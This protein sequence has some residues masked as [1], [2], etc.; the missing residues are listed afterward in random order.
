MLNYLV[1][2]LLM[3]LGTLVVVSVIAFAI[4]QLPPGDYVTAYVGILEDGGDV[5]TDDREAALRDS[6]A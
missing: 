3:A 5:V 1:R 4:I 6:T 2:R